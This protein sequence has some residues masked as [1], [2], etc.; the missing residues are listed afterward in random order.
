MFDHIMHLRITD[1]N[2][3]VMRLIAKN[4]HIHTQTYDFKFFLRV[5]KNLGVPTWF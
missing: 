2:R 5:R 1:T 3:S 4:K